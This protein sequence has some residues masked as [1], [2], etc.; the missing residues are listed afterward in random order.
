M[1][2]NFT[3]LFGGAAIFTTIAMI[4]NQIKFFFSRLFNLFVVEVK[5]EG[6]IPLALSIYLKENF[7]RVKFQPLKFS[8]V[9]EFVKSVKRRWVISY[10][11]IDLS[12]RTIFFHGWKP[13]IISASANMNNAPARP[14]DSTVSISF[15][16]GCFD[17]D[18]IIVKSTELLNE[19]STKTQ[20]TDRFY[21]K[22]HFGRSGQRETDGMQNYGESGKIVEAATDSGGGTDLFIG[23]KRFLKYEMDDI[24]EENEG[25]KK[26]KTLAF[27]KEIEGL[28]EEIKRWKE[29][30]SWYKEK[31]IP[32]KRGW[33]LFGKTGTGKS[34]LT[35]A[36][37][38]YLDLPIHIFDI[39]S[40][41]NY[42]FHSKWS[43][44][45]RSTP[46]M[47][48]IE[49][50]DAVFNGRENIKNSQTSSDLLTFDCLLNCIDGIENT[51]G[52][53]LIIT[54]NRVEF[55]DDALG[56][57]RS[58]KHVNG[59]HIS[60]RPGRI[61]RAF[62]LKSLDK[63]CRIKVANRILCD[64][65]EFIDKIVE[66]GEGDSGAQFQERCTQIAL[67]CFWDQREKNNNL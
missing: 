61:D 17:I 2:T 11:E 52:L 38:Q 29:S 56:K 30:E 50:I 57:P 23:N 49:D 59:T 27:P 67:K 62:E 58:D 26:L 33:L 48:L 13:L 25:D 41:S 46:C 34:S 1:E 20:R 24:G 9:R 19:R 15:I 65:K 42:D 3:T 32:W 40:M 39:S 28:I 21:V 16:R 44:M 31:S 12:G 5:V 53:F 36:I 6:K 43:D 47:A 60:T 63:E 14:I 45:L 8:T 10:E 22:R 35:K 18:D 51:D 64:C 37:G 55:L 7:Y 66:D 4:W 54:T